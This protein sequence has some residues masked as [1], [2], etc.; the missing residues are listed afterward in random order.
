MKKAFLFLLLFFTKTFVF[1]QI[2]FQED[3][4]K[5]T[6]SAP[7]FATSYFKT[8]CNSSIVKTSQGVDCGSYIFQNELTIDV[9]GNGYFLFHP[10]PYKTSGQEYFGTCWGTLTPLK[11]TP[12][13]L[14]RFSFYIANA[15]PSSFAVFEPFING[16]S[17]GSPTQAKNGY[18]NQSWTKLSFCWNSGSNTEAILRIDD[19]LDTA[20]GNDFA[21]DNIIFEKIGTSV[22]S[23]LNVKLCNAPSYL[24]NNVTYTKSGIY[25]IKVK[26][27][28]ECDSLV[29]LNLVINENVKISKNIQ[30][31]QGQK[32]KIGNKFYDQKGV[33]TDTITAKID[34]DTIS[35]IT[36]TIIEPT[37][38]KIKQDTTIFEG[39]SI[40]LVPQTNLKNIQ[41]TWSPSDS[42][43]CTTCF[44]PKAKPKES[45]LYELKG[46]DTNGCNYF[47]KVSINVT[48]VCQNKIYIPNTFS[49]NDD[50]KNDR[51][52]VFSNDCTVNILTMKVFDRWGS[53]VFE[54][55]NI[56]TNDPE[57]AWDGS[58]LKKDAQ[59]SIYTYYIEIE[60][61][62]K[63]MQIYKGDVMLIR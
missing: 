5:G 46:K 54:A 12:N 63:K 41:W 58:F 35:T 50:G 7:F 32:I 33:Y 9:S 45:I 47:G 8:P 29:V 27:N 20:V 51:F 48:P 28:G 18:G 22:P 17:I 21:I 4:E 52:M 39:E 19:L 40:F 38:I 13:T 30:L 25:N 31:C 23:I 15:F 34:C 2:I 6:N 43:S 56:P 37:A 3:F 53:L 14:Y 57:Y 49:P 59:S 60:D 26:K 44:S 62:R 36:V 10:T 1:T 42:L 55:N 16:E 61:F 11:V 24:F